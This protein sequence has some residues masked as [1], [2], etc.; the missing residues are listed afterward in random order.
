MSD[1]MFA[2]LAGKQRPPLLDR[3]FSPDIFSPDSW[4][5][6]RWLFLRTLGGVFFSAFYALWF[7]INGLIGPRGILPA[8]EYCRLAKAALGWEAYWLIPSPSRVSSSE[9]ALLSVG[10]L[11]RR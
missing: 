2:S 11:C 10:A 3:W 7:Q 5:R 8:G 4:L 1:Y 6:A 9:K